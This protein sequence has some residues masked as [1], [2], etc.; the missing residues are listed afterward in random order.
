SALR[1]RSREPWS[2]QLWRPYTRAS[3]HLVARHR[4]LESKARALALRRVDPDAPTHRVHELLRD[5]QSEP[6]AG[7]AVPRG[8]LCPVELAE[9]PLA[10]RRGDPHA[11]VDDAH[12]DAVGV[13][14]RADGHLAALRRVAQ[15]VL[16]QDVEDLP[17]LVGIRLG[18]ER[19]LGE[20]DLEA[21]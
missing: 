19:L 4:K 20:V 11:L 16:D 10:L 2:S 7:G 6:R 1:R 14:P 13:S 8:G 9:D 21:E 17:D 3:G 5:E 15:R 18:R 12:L